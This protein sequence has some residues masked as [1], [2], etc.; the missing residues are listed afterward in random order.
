M[1]HKR[2][3]AISPSNLLLLVGSGFMLILLWQLRNLLVI[4]MIAVVIASTLAPLVKSVEK[5]GIPPWLAV[6]FVYLGLLTL[7]TGMSLILGPTIIAQIQRLLQKLP[8]YLDILETEFQNWV[9]RRGFTQPEVLDF[10]NQLLDLQSLVSWTL[11]YSQKF[12]IGVGGVTRGILGG[13]FNV[14]VAVLLSGYMLSGSKKLIG[15]IVNLFPHPWDERLE[16]QVIPISQRMGGYIQGRLLVSFILGLVVSLGLRFLGISEFA[17]GLGTIAG[18]TNLIPFFG[19]VL[20]SIPAL[21]VAIAQGGWVFLWVLLLFLFIQNVETYVL[22]PLLVGSSVNVSP[23]YQLLAVLS[24]VQI[25][26]IL[27][28]LIVP[29]WVAGA[30]VLL[31]NLYL[32]PK[33]QAQGRAIPL[34]EPK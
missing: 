30:G 20:G 19:P 2:I 34:S 27:G 33:L 28:A 11:S 21:I 18:I 6:I 1:I 25:L 31:Q 29:P 24:G 5:R 32:I 10:I 14:I 15:G 16:A 23:L 4:L 9:T 12:L 8:V 13:V 7:I 26:G 17:L 3:I 22:D